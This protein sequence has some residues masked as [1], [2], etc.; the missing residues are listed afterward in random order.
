MSL[1]R[2][3]L[4]ARS[5][6]RRFGAA[7][8]I[9]SPQLAQAALSASFRELH[10]GHRMTL[11]ITA[12]WMP[13]IAVGSGQWAV[14]SEQ[15]AEDRGHRGGGG[16]P[17]AYCLL[18]TAHCEPRQPRTVSSPSPSKSSLDV[19]AEL[20]IVEIEARALVGARNVLIRK[21]ALVIRDQNF[22]PVTADGALDADRPA[23]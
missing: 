7:L 8:I 2:R 17:P 20:H 16:R 4:T 22:E 18:P 23:E 12:R 11:A 10:S 9:S 15:W 3:F 14:G 5:S 21:G 13:L 1:S 19:E 6:D